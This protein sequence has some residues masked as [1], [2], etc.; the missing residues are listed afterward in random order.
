AIAQVEHLPGLVVDDPLDTTE[1]RELT[2]AVWRHL[3]VKAKTAVAEVPVQGGENLA[4]WLDSHALARAEIQRRVRGT[5]QPALDM[6]IAPDAEPSERK[7]EPVVRGN[8]HG[9]QENPERDVSRPELARVLPRV[10]PLERLGSAEQ[11]GRLAGVPL[12]A[13]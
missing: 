1:D 10:P 13:V 11:L 5:S 12:L 9:L 6:G 4:L 3:D 8:Q 2:A 7:S